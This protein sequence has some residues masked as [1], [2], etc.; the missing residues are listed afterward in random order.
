MRRRLRPI[1]RGRLYPPQAAWRQRSSTSGRAGSGQHALIA[2]QARR[3]VAGPVGVATGFGGHGLKH[4]TG[5]RVGSSAG[6]SSTGDE[7][8]L[9]G[10]SRH[11]ES[12]GCRREG[13][14]GHAALMQ[15]MTWWFHGGRRALRRRARARQARGGVRGR[16]GAERLAALRPRPRRRPKAAIGRAV[17]AHQLQEEPGAIASNCRDDPVAHTRAGG[18][19]CRR[20]GGAAETAAGGCARRDTERMHLRRARRTRPSTRRITP[21]RAGRSA[22][23]E[24]APRRHPRRQHGCTPR[25]RPSRLAIK[26]GRFE[27]QVNVP[28]RSSRSAASAAE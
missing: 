5:W 2:A 17:P 13:G 28:A 24:R 16:A 7:T 8:T 21:R 11:L 9:A 18:G 23:P 12:C 27:K 26:A 1:S 3:A 6:P 19:W 14:F 22:G 20:C 15:S 10:C 25:Q 4:P